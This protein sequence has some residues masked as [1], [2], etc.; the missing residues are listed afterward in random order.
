[1]TLTA[2]GILHLRQVRSAACRG[3]G[4]AQQAAAIELAEV[5]RAAAPDLADTDIAARLLQLTATTAE[6]DTAGAWLIALTAAT[7]AGPALDGEPAH[8]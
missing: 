7:I 3:G 8:V 4:C 1:M 6:Q 5:A 2:I